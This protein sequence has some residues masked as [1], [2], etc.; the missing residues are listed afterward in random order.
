MTDNTD[1][2]IISHTDVGF[3]PNR[4]FPQLSDNMSV[5][6][7]SSLVREFGE[8]P[9]CGHDIDPDVKN[10]VEIDRDIEWT[11]M[12]TDYKEPRRAC[13][14]SSAHE[15]ANCGTMLHIFVEEKA[16]PARWSKIPD[17]QWAKSQL[18]IEIEN[19]NYFVCNPNAISIT[20]SRH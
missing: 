11:D 20:E 18:W 2:T 15:C 17:E 10:G 5:A 19:G 1:V 12:S 6:T 3:V 9:N 13:D 14:R 4:F 16:R 8:C 7:A